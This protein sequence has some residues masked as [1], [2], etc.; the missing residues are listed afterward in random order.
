MLVQMG[1]DWA[2]RESV[3]RLRCGEKHR[4]LK[5]V[6][7]LE[8]VDELM[9]AAQQLGGN[10]VG[11]E[12]SIEAGDAGLAA[13]LHAR[14][15]VVYVQDAKQ[16]RRFAESLTSSGAKDDERDAETLLRM[17]DSSHHRI[18][19]WEPPEALRETAGVLLDDHDDVLSKIQRATNQLRE[20]LVKVHPALERSLSQM[21]TQA[22]LAVVE[23]VPTWQDGA[24]LSEHDREELLG[25]CRFH[26]KRRAAIVSALAE[27][28][29]A[30]ASEVRAA[31][32]AR[33]RRLVGE[34][35]QLR[36]QQADIDSA[37]DKLAERYTEST[38][39]RST[40]GIGVTLAISLLALG[41]VNL[42][43]G[44]RDDLAVWC[45]ASPVK[46]QSGKSLNVVRMRKSAPVRG[47]RTSYLLAMQAMMRLKW[48]KAQYAYLRQ[49]GK[50]HGT[51]LRII[52]RSLLRLL[53][54]LLR[55]GEAYDET[56]YIK[57]LQSKGV[58]WAQ[59]VLSTV[60]EANELDEAA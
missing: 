11:V 54:A 25:R 46:R 24:A 53:A 8:G 26:S 48:A 51:A 27:P 45:G 55:T 12:V 49:H 30:M 2:R 1:I 9:A 10:D 5:V 15:A 3:A 17:L 35:R 60:E 19:A 56:R 44:D 34:L 14:E 18:E 47:R 50:N 33:V 39:L 21:W 57:A 36:K 23:A 42:A 6:R 43:Q 4:K 59:G 20:E 13:A 58:V 40:P 28:W 7:S 38:T 32:A 16:A 22:A 31:H 52:A 41:A 37:M 29:V